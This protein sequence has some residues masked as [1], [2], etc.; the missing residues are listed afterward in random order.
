[1]STNRRTSLSGSRVISGYL[2]AVSLP[3][4]L[5]FLLATVRSTLNLSSDVLVFL[6]VCVVAALIGGLGPALVSAVTG[7]ML[8]NYYFT[9]PVHTLSVEDPNNALA[10]AVFLAVAML[11]SSAVD[12]AARRTDEAARAAAEAAGLAQ[13][14]RTRTALL[15]A[16][17]HDLRTPLAAAKAAL[18]TLRSIDLELVEADREELLATADESLDRLTGLIENLLD[19]S[20]LQA[21]AM[22]VQLRAVA[23]EEVVARVLDDLGSPATNVVV[24]LTASPPDLEADPGL[25]ERVLVNLL[26]NALRYSPPEHPPM[27]TASR[28]GSQ[29]EI[30]VVDRGPGIPQDQRDQV[31]LP[32]QRL[33]DTD[34]TTGVGLG[35]ALARGLTEAMQG[36]LDLEDTP[37]GGLTLVVRLRAGAPHEAAPQPGLRERAQRGAPGSAP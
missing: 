10:L 31:F 32:F 33:G 24:E 17:G 29:V 21:G 2:A 18:S 9:P 35:L 16:V 28:A 20:R 12:L 19:M 23:L 6:L 4:L 1:V 36:T 34:N 37:E 22:A 14:D 30:R 15:A 5:T 11:V 13:V 7:S 27:L 8:L 26:A 3:A 25:L